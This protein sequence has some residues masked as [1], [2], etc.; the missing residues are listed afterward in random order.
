MRTRVE[1]FP[2]ELTTVTADLRRR[3]EDASTE[4][5]AGYLATD[6][7]LQA[8][9]ELRRNVILTARLALGQ[10]DFEAVDRDDRRLGLTLSGV[11][12]LNRR[13]GLRLSYAHLQLDSSGRSAVQGYTVNRIILGTVVQ[14]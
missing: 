4:V 14:F 11:Y 8:D 10:D 2:S 3:V 1:Y 13:V 7:S 12:L 5:V 9:H 6:F